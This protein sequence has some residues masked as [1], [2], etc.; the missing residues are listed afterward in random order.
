MGGQKPPPAFLA[1]SQT[2]DRSTSM[3]AW[4]LSF[5]CSIFTLLNLECKIRAHPLLPRHQDLAENQVGGGREEQLPPPLQTN[6]PSPQV[7]KLPWAPW[8][9]RGGPP[10]WGGQGGEAPPPSCLSAFLQFSTISAPLGVL[11]PIPFPQSPSQ[12]TEP[13]EF[14]PRQPKLLGCAGR[15]R[16]HCWVRKRALPQSAHH[17]GRCPRAH[18]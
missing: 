18:L 4:S 7:Q 2:L 10:L 1:S 11:P 12:A 14:L 17:P 16:K 15:R 6:P 5:L 3:L 13:V 8:S 9:G